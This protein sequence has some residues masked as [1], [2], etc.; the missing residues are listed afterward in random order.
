MPHTLIPDETRTRLAEYLASLQAGSAFAGKRLKDNLAGL[1]SAT[2]TEAGFLDALLNTKPPQI[3]AESAVAGD[4]SDWNLTELGILGDI[5]IAVRVTVFDNGHH[6]VP[7]PHVEPFAGTLV[8][9][10]A[11]SPAVSGIEIPPAGR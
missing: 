3:F 10:S 5:S 7:V 8:F 2:L 4:G 9:T 11:R 6:T 1:E